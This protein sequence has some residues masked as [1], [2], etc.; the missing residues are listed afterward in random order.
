MTDPSNEPDRL[1][2]PEDATREPDPDNDPFR[3][4]KRNCTVYCLHCQQKYDSFRIHW[5]E[6]VGADGRKKGFWR[7][8]TPGCGG[9]G[10]QFDIY[11]TDPNYVDEEDRG[12]TGGWFDDDGNPVPPPFTDDE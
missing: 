1:D 4:P 2:M 5:V 8:P 10:F 6:S 7:C 3:P 12:M 11:P 9:A